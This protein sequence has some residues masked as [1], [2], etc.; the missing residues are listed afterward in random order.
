MEDILNQKK[1]FTPGE[2]AELLMV[3]PITVRLWSQKGELE[4]VTTPGGH[5]RYLYK[6]IK[7]FARDR[8]LPLG[9]EANSGLRVLIIDDDEQFAHY[10]EE[11]L[12][13][14]S[15]IS[16]IKHALDGFKA[17]SLVYTFEPQIVLLDLRMPY[18]DGFVVCSDLKKNQTT[19]DIKVIAMTGY[20]NKLNVDRILDNGAETCL[21]KPFESKELFEAMG[22]ETIE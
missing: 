22:L 7:T 2:V 5:R 17:G 20:Y 10:L 14:C 3:S 12:Q 9:S 21:Q 4:S 11:L 6:H 8:N 15:E 1:Y 16:A 13:D 18:V 19:K